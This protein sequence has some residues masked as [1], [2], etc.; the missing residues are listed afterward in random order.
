MINDRKKEVEEWENR[1][2]SKERMTGRVNEIFQDY[3]RRQV[4]NV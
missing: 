2:E 1:K 4:R 3:R